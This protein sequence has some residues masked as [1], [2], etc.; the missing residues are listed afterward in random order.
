MKYYIWGLF[1]CIVWQPDKILYYE[2]M[3]VFPAFLFSVLNKKTKIYI[4][5]HGY[6]T[7]TEYNRT[8]LSRLPY[9]VEKKFILPKAYW[10]S[11]TNKERLEL[12]LNDINLSFNKDI[13][14]IVPNYPP[15]KWS[16][17]LKQSRNQS[18]PIS[19]VYV[20][21]FSSIDNLYVKEIT[22]W[23]TSHNGALTLDIYSFNI[24]AFVRE[25]I[26]SL[27]SPYIKLHKAINYNNIPD[28][29]T[30]YDIGL[31]IYKVLDYNFK[32]NAPNKLFEYITCGLDVWYPQEMIGCQSFNTLNCYPK[33]IG[34]DFT[35]LYKYNIDN[36]ISKKN[37]TL[38][39]KN[40]TCEKATQDLLI[41]LNHHVSN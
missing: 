7:L 28:I 12:F 38:N 37:C 18:K 22:T 17:F 30:Q 36:L 29:I 9:M 41:S 2:S 20:G 23:V 21:S 6:F 8:F 4:H 14:H 19:L 27:D 34:L 39:E 11:H 25:Y 35:N 24:P 31:I 13:H 10:I 3:S 32:Y 1:K 33:I 40:Y 5:Y 15:A 16:R 26:N